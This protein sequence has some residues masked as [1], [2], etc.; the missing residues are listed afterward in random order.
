[1]A[2]KIKL[3]GRS[4]NQLGNSDADTIIKTKGQLKLQYGNKFID[5]VKD[6]KLNV[7][8]EFIFKVKS[9]DNITGNNGIYVCNDG[10]IYLKVG[11][12]IVNLVGEVGTTYISFL[13]PQETTS[14]QKHQALV[15]IGFLHESLDSIDQN[16]L[17]NGIVYVESEQKLYTIV[18][19]TVTEL[20]VTFPNPFTDQFVIA[21]T[22][23]E[24]GALLIKGTGVENSLAFESLF[25][26]V[27]DGS[28]N[29]NS[30]GDIIYKIGETQVLSLSMLSAL[31]NVPVS[32]SMFQSP[33]ASR[34][35][36]FRLYVQNNEQSYLE[37][38]NLI[39]R[40]P[41]NASSIH[42]FPEYWLM[43]NNIITQ[44][45]TAQSEETTKETTEETPE[46]TTEETQESDQLSIKLSQSNEFNIGDIVVFY[47][48]STERISLGMG[49]VNKYDENGNSL[50]FG[51][52]F[53][54]LYIFQCGQKKYASAQNL[55][56]AAYYNAAASCI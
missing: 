29:F 56:G 25:I 12:S 45:T 50:D 3:F 48:K 20:V 31:F 54:R 41:S 9:I 23:S 42:L 5:L 13:V 30:D 22:N 4:Y 21:K 19:G 26:Y 10:S 38:D 51:F 27:D 17:Q 6:G 53:R 28:T 7:N 33:N 52:G 44:A 18:N 55:F 2:D 43:K 34:Q 36:G 35:S 47:K 11:D 8:T 32:G 16:S 24:K 39:L 14:D 49:E 1:M 46:D 40:N 15:N 37:V